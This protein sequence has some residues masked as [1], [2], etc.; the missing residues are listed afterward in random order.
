MYRSRSTFDVW[1]SISRAAVVYRSRKIVRSRSLEN[2]WTGFH[3]LKFLFDLQK[4][5][6]FE[7][8]LPH[9]N[10]IIFTKKIFSRR[11]RPR[12]GE[13]TQSEEEKLFLTLISIIK[14]LSPGCLI[15]KIKR[16]LLL[17]TI[18]SPLAPVNIL[19]APPNEPLGVK[20]DKV[21]R[22]YWRDGCEIS[23]RRSKSLVNFYR[24]KKVMKS[25]FYSPRW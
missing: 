2:Y 3:L 22:F 13:K 10:Y 23:A 19:I 1:I 24:F 11:R 14:N 15:E 8:V 12:P 16:K 7:K 6:L 4:S 5:C 20:P 21:S 25:S 18:S 17:Y 9:P